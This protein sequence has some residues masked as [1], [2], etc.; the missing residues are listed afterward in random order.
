MQWFSCCLNIS[1]SFTFLDYSLIHSFVLT[2]QFLSALNFSTFSA[3]DCSNLII[4][5]CF[6]WGQN[7]S[8]RVLMQ[9]EHPE[10][11]F[12]STEN[13]SNR[14]NP[15]TFFLF[16][17]GGWSTCSSLGDNWMWRCSAHSYFLLREARMLLLTVVVQLLG[18]LRGHF[19]CVLA[20]SSSLPPAGCLIQ[21]CLISSRRTFL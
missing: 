17:P 1:T 3:S 2:L 19:P 13:T 11:V 16:L 10:F 8:E 5:L 6:Q 7:R 12:R 9:Q 21:S 14:Q 15:T 18:H 4:F 20:A